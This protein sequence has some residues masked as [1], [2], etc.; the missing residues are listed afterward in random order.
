MVLILMRGC[1]GWSPWIREDD[2]FDGKLTQNQHGELGLF[3]HPNGW[4]T[5]MHQRCQ[6]YCPNGQSRFPGASTIRFFWRPPTRRSKLDVA[7]QVLG[8]SR[9]YDFALLDRL[10]SNVAGEVHLLQ[11][12]T[13]PVAVT[14]GAEAGATA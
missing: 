7:A 14:V 1:H 3:R 2:H 8:L 6:R 11:P 13:E 9:A 5:K 10:G 4:H 12:R